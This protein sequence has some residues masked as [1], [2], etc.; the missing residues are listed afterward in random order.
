MLYPTRLNCDQM[1]CYAEKRK[2]L[3]TKAFRERSRLNDGLRGLIDYVATK[4]PEESEE[5]LLDDSFAVVKDEDFPNA[6]FKES[7]VLT[8]KGIKEV[9]KVKLEEEAP[10]LEMKD[11]NALDIVANL[12]PRSF[13]KLCMNLQAIIDK[14]KIRIPKKYLY[15]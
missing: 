2:T 9:S 10:E 6:N 15:F 11:A 5:V 1:A 4:L 8:N 7:Y 3:D 12:D 13:N 14:H